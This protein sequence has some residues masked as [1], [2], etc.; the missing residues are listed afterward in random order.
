MTSTLPEYRISLVS[1]D[2]DDSVLLAPDWHATA[3]A[4]AIRMVT[5]NF[6]RLNLGI[7]VVF[8]I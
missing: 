8:I 1:V 2:G 4:A 5:I 6:M 3:N 7:N